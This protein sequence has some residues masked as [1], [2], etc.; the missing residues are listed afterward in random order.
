MYPGAPFRRFLALAILLGWAAV[1]ADA[2][3]QPRF[4]GISLVAILLVPAVVYAVR[5]GGRR[6]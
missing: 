3:A 6:S 5:T 1:L 4:D 2:L